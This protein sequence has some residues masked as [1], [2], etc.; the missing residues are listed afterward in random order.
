MMEF[1]VLEVSVGWGRD[2]ALRR[3]GSKRPPG[4]R[5]AFKRLVALC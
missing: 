4:G 2:V 1:E 3:T 5:R